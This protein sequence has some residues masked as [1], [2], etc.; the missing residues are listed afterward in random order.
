MFLSSLIFTMN[1]LT[2]RP[3][4]IIF[5]THRLEHRIGFSPAFLFVTNLI[6]LL[7]VDRVIV[8]LRS[9]L[10]TRFCWVASFWHLSSILSCEL[11]TDLNNEY[12]I[13]IVK[14][15]S[16]SNKLW[17]SSYQ[18]TAGKPLLHSISK[19]L[20]FIPATTTFD[21]EKLWF[22]FD[23]VIVEKIVL[24][25]NSLVKI[26]VLQEGRYEGSNCSCSG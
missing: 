23:T 13:R 25:I 4:E 16:L 17:Q 15:L 3:L 18:E 11:G 2:N 1:H 14:T 7:L 6:H 10:F 21:V 22:S 26:N 9:A 19:S 24:L 20:D 5:T 8:H 12:L